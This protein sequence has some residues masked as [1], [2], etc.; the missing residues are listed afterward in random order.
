MFFT[1][2]FFV[3]YP[4][5]FFPGTKIQPWGAPP[6]STCSRRLVLAVLRSGCGPSP[7][8]LCYLSALGEAFPVP[9][10][11]DA[12]GSPLSLLQPILV[13]SPSRPACA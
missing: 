8:F 9:Q 5:S 7:V 13:F 6:H 1:L 4:R 2:L 3:P 11:A 12:L 10:S